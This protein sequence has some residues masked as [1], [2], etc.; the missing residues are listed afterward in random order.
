[1]IAD[2]HVK[3]KNNSTDSEQENVR[4]FFVNATALKSE[5]EILNNDMDKF[6]EKYN[7]EK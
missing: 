7:I 6:S 1:M 5:Q 3:G 4:T 2:I